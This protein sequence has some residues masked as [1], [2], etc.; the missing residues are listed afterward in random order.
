MMCIGRVYPARKLIVSKIAVRVDQTLT[1]ALET[2]QWHKR[3]VA[4]KDSKYTYVLYMII[5]RTF[6]T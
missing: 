1:K 6:R 3:V 4:K 5:V 2:S